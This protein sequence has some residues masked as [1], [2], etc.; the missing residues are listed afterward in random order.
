M[1]T[2][3][4]SGTVTFLFTDVERSTQKAQ[5]PGEG[6]AA[7]LAAQ[8]LL[9]S[10]FHRFHGRVV[11]TRRDSFLVAFA[12]PADAV[13]ASV[14]AQRALAEHAWPGEDVVRVRMGMHTGAP[15]LT[16]VGYVGLDVHIAPALCAAAH[17]GQILLSQAARDLAVQRLPDGVSLR[18]LGEHRLKDLKQPRRVFQLVSSE[19]LDAFPPLRSLD[20]RPHN[21]P[22]QL[23]SFVGRRSEMVEIKRLLTTTRLLT[24]T[25]PGGAG[26]TRLALQVAAD[27]ADAY[28]NGVW[29][30]ELAPLADPELVPA[31]AA[32]V[33]GI[34]EQPG[35]PILNSLVDHLSS[36]NM[37]LVLDNCEHV[38]DACARLAEALLRAC[39]NLTILATSR[40]SLGLT[41]ETAWT[42]PSLSLP[43]LRQHRP[44]FVVLS[45]SEAVQLFVDRAVAVQ[46][47]V[48]LAEMNALA[49]AQ[50]CQ[51]LDGIPLAIELAAARVKL[52]NP[53]EIAA[54]LD[55]RFTLLTA[56]SRTALPRHQTLRAAIDWSYDLLTERER[57]LLRRLSVFAGGWTLEAAESVCS[58][59]EAESRYDA[60]SPPAFGLLPSEILD[61][62]SRLV[63]K[64]LIIVDKLGGETR[65]HMLETIRQYAREKLAESGEKDRVWDRYLDFFSKLAE[66]AEIQLDGADQADWLNRL[67]SDHGNLRAALDW[68]RMANGN[69]EVGLRLAGSLA[70]FWQIRGYWH[71]G[72]EQLSAVL[73]REEAAGPTAARAKALYNA[74]IM[75]YLQSDYPATRHSLEAS[76]SIHREL[77]PA[78]Q[79]SIA[80]ALIMLGDMETQVGHYATAFS[81]IQEALGIMRELEDVGGMAAALWQLG[82]GAVRQGEY[83]QAVHLFEQALPLL[84]QTGDKRQ[85]AIVLT[86]L[87]EVALRQAEHERATALEKESLALRREIGDKWGI[88]VSLGNFAWL[89]LRRNDLEEAA[90]LLE[91]SVTLRHEMGDQGGI[92]WCLEKLAEIALIRGQRGPASR[93]V[94]DLQRAARLFGA[95]ATLRAPIGSV[96]D[97]VDAPEH[98]RQ[99]AVVREQLGV[100]PFEMT[101]SEGQAMTLEQAIEYALGPPA[102]RKEGAQP[103]S[104]RQTTGQEF[105]GL[106]GREREVAARIA[107]ADSNREIAQELVVSERTVET[108]VANILSKLGF[109]RRAQIRKWALERGLVKR[110]T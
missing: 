51:R 14:M 107:R 97:L 99:L 72:R 30:I 27:L 4:P 86:L 24:L 105:G 93:R 84:R 74:G 11:D 95:A 46:P 64:S 6:S 25:G 67:E 104:P 45:K 100:T 32:V 71:E 58:M 29:L 102:R 88:A 3:L 44:T 60:G 66:E 101:W 68:S 48:G 19:L 61:L 7:V 57:V 81:L 76:L 49:V 23:T 80:Q 42:L 94:E 54:R 31:A 1:R 34:R 98:E 90:G 78:Y 35:Q 108:H 33:L 106:T 92:A 63:D 28:D 55:D 103:P 10:A 69:A 59:Y 36:K 18:D 109:T 17:G 22:I 13:A 20:A 82:T 38:I 40:E 96:I 83:E 89:A 52:L 37:M 75:A 8:K 85:M 77:G 26:K 110:D 87:A 56:G 70:K 21:L 50:V 43:D 73:S 5:R 39:P 12:R 91:E 65:F 15:P 47:G 62:L 79:V 9:G 16:A 2:D 53:A 41:G